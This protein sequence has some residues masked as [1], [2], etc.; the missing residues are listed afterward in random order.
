MVPIFKVTVE[1]VEEHTTYVIAAD[2]AAAL[3]VPM[4]ADWYS[5]D[6]AKPSKRATQANIVDSIH[7]VP[8]GWRDALPWGPA[9][10]EKTVRQW[11]RKKA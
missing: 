5:I 8:K 9:A 1:V 7:A 10:D 4:Q 6:D 11:L 3:Q 2:E